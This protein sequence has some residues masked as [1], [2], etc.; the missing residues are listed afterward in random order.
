MTSICAPLNES[1]LSVNGSSA[2]VTQ[3]STPNTPA[4]DQENVSAMLNDLQQLVQQI[5]DP[6]EDEAKVANAPLVNGGRRIA[7]R[8]SSKSSTS[9]LRS[10]RRRNRSGDASQSSASSRPDTSS[11]HMSLDEDVSE[12]IPPPPQPPLSMLSDSTATGSILSCYSNFYTLSFSL[13]HQVR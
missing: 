11:D 6:E 10:E 7:L 8:N 3:V 13:Q 2:K 12:L 4:I 9:V 1:L 5:T